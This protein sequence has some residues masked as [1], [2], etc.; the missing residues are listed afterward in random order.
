MHKFIIVLAL[1]LTALT[2]C[3]GTSKSTSTGGGGSPEGHSSLACEHFT[4]IMGD[5]TSGILT[6][7]ELRSKISEV[8]DSATSSAVRSAATD[9]LAAITRRN[10]TAVVTAASDLADACAAAAK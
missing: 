4:N 9:L 8:R 1:T 10:N 7:A 2:A 3:G 6:D 5:V